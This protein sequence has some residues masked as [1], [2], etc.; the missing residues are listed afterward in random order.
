MLYNTRKLVEENGDKLPEAEK[1]AAEE[2]FKNSEKVLEEH[3]EPTDPEPL[4]AALEALQAVA[5]KLA[6]AMY[7]GQ[8]PEGEG[9]APAEEA[10]SEDA[11]DDGVIDA[12]FE[13]TT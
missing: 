1:L 10:P 5:H 2:E 3:K 9:D 8:S 6:E 7:K 11:G 4:R 13:E 12:E